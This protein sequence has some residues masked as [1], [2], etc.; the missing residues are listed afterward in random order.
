MIV[1]FTDFGR[2]DSYVGQMH[3]R[4]VQLAPE[5][6]IIDLLHTVPAFDIRAAAY[7]LPA[8]LEEFPPETIFVCVVDPGV[9]GHRRPLLLKV[10]GRWLIGPDNGLFNLVA[11]RARRLDSWEI[12]WRPETLSHSFHGRD[13]F[14][15]VAATL[16]QGRQA[17]C[18]PCA[19]E[20][21]AA[22]GDW[23]DDL[24][25]IIYL[26]HY[27]NAM[28]GLRAEGISPDT[29]FRLRGAEVGYA[30]TFIEAPPQQPF[31]YANANGLVE[32][33]CNQASARERLGIQPGDEL[34]WLS[35]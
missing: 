13:L 32:I 14:A 23:P 21:P 18:R 26:D 22:D 12:L 31:W 29:R 35:Q 20:L 11:R 1:L 8:Y 2:D 15:P 6:P 3:A 25:R 34:Q 16:A 27:G 28:S 19:L 9:G 7:L 24:P 17:A 4:L 10:D 33:A 5:M 30:R